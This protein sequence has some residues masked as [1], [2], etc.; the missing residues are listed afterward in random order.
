[1]AEADDEQPFQMPKPVTINLGPLRELHVWSQFIKQLRLDNRFILSDDVNVFIKQVMKYISKRRVGKLEQG[2]RLYRAR[3]HPPSFGTIVD[4]S[5]DELM[6]PEPRIA[7]AGRL[8]PE[9]IPFLYTAGDETTAVAEMRPSKG[10]DVTIAE[11]ELM[12]DATIVDATLDDINA[13]NAGDE[14]PWEEGARTTWQTISFMF[15]VPHHPED[16]LS[17][18]PT[19]YLSEVIKN[20]GYDGIRYPSALNSGGWNLA[21]FDTKAAEYRSRKK[22]RVTDVKYQVEQKRR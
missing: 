20:A 11:L 6:A 2:H 16:S 13:P 1:M 14:K 5:D 22:V 4:F 15:S 21:L 18:V 7:T 9:G 12:K 8:N 10:I 19:Q 3:T 17:Y